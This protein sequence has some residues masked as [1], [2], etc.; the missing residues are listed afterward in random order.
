MPWHYSYLPQREQAYQKN[1]LD[2]SQE[3]SVQRLAQCRDC[4]FHL[5]LLCF[6]W[7][8]MRTADARRLRCLNPQPSACLSSSESPCRFS[9][10]CGRAVCPPLPPWGFSR[11]VVNLPF[12]FWQL[13]TFC[14][15][16]CYVC[17]KRLELPSDQTPDPGMGLG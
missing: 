3:G 2:L 12:C 8:N 17:F 14:V 16:L 6:K 5:T 7:G 10:G 13:G 15:L 4:E 1:N 9:P 11:L